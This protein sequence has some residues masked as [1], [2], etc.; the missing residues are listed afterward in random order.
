LRDHCALLAQR[1]G[2]AAGRGAIVFFAAAPRWAF[3]TLRF[4]TAV[5]FVVAIVD[6]YF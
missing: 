4:A 5:C 6:P 1:G 3:L 2:V